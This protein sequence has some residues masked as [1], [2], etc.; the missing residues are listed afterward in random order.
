MPP[1]IVENFVDKR[2]K[3]R[4]FSKFVAITFG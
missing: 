1:P 3:T 4:G 2:P